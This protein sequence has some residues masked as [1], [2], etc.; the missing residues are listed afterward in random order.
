VFVCRVA[1]VDKTYFT[2]CVT[3]FSETQILFQ[4]EP[5]ARRRS[6]VNCINVLSAAFTLTDPKSAKKYSQVVSLFA[7]FRSLLVKYW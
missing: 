6:G 7:L 1:K 4:I 3:S 2:K 5:F